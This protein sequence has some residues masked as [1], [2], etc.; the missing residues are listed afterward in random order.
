MGQEENEALMT[1]H[2]AESQEEEVSIFNGES[3]TF[4]LINKTNS[5]K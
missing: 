5:E 4:T 3:H 2:Q 1:C